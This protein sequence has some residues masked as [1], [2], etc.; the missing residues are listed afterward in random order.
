MTTAHPLSWY[1]SP[2]GNDVWSG[3]LAAPNATRTDGPFRTLEKAAEMVGPGSICWLRQGTY[4]ETLKPIRSGVA[5]QPIVFRNYPNETAVISG[6]DCLTGWD[7]VDGRIFT[8]PMAWDLLDQNQLFANG[9]MLTEARWPK[10]NGTLLQPV[11]ATAQT[12]TASTLTDPTL[13]G[14]DGA[15]TGALLWCAGGDRWIC[16]SEPVTGYDAATQTLS[17]TMTKPKPEHWYIVRDGSPYV[18]MGVRAAL[19]A[20]GEW[21]Y[22]RA[23]A[24]MLLI[25]PGGIDLTTGVIE[26]KRR[27]HCI[28]LAGLSH[29]QVIGLGFRAG[30]VFTDNQTSN[31]LLAMC[32]GEYVAHSFQRDISQEAGVL[33]RGQDNEVNSCEL[34]G[35]S[36]SILSVTGRGHRI[37]NCYIHDGNY[38]AKWTG[39]VALAGRKILFSHNTVRDSG[40]DLVSIHGLM[41]SLIQ[42]NDL[43]HA[44]W[45]TSDLGMLYG[46]STDFMNTVIRY[47]RVHDNCAKGF[48]TGIYFDHCSHNAIVHHNVITHVANDPIRINNPSYFNLVLNN[49]CYATG[50]IATFDHTHRNDLFGTRYINNIFNQPITLPEHVRQEHNQVC[51]DPGYANPPAG[52]FTVKGGAGGLGAFAAGQPVW[53]AGH[54]FAAPPSVTWEVPDFAGMN[55]IHNSGFE[56]G[57]LEGWR[58]IGPGEITLTVGNGWG[59]TINGGTTCE[60]TG[61]SNYELCLG[62]GHCGVA[63]SV[64][65]L[66]PNQPHIFSG[67]VRVSAPTESVRLGVRAPDGTETWSAPVTAIVWTRVLVD[68]MTGPGQLEVTVLVQKNSDGPG[69]AFADNLGLPLVKQRGSKHS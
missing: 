9:G 40:R 67:W 19:D 55:L 3:R 46:H 58:T 69:Q 54:D 65:G 14:T 25:P 39:A 57:T 66:S 48:A 38:A 45:L 28:N 21:W 53:K 35:S 49:S 15:W 59:N 7:S 50:A 61:T 5:G 27:Q 37:I 47:N 41:E 32:T 51:A 22:D 42:F 30:G 26:A 36:T 56:L 2:A 63:Q 33:I 10:N 12:G 20:E 24:R 8:A 31:I 17:F 29:I 34:S 6:A 16:W 62:K 64:Q 60:N 44:G 23:S 1:V 18:L 4:R 11:R 68:F 52:D 43:S 13:P